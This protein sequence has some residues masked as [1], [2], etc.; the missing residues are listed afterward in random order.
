V[1]TGV[2]A[3]VVALPSIVSSI[4]YLNQSED[5]LL[6]PAQIGNLLGPV[7]WS[8]AF[9]IWFAFD[10]RL[11]EP[12]RETLTVIG[13]LLAALFTVFGVLDALARRRAALLLA[14]ITGLAG[15][16]VISSRY[17]I[18]F[19]AKSYMALAPALG[20]ATAAGVLWLW[21]RSTRERAGALVLGS[22]L[23]LGVLVS[24]GY[25][26]AGVWNTPKDRFQE[27]IDIG[28]RF[29]GKGP[30]LVNEREEYSK[31][32]LR[33]SLPWESWGSWQ[34]DRGLRF[35][36]VPAVPTTPDF[37]Y[38]TD[39][40]MARFKLLLE[41]KRPGGSRP[42]GNFEPVYE[43]AHYRVWRRVGDP[44]RVHLPLGLKGLSGSSHL[45]CGDPSAKRLLDRARRS[46]SRIRIAL[47]RSVPIVSEPKQWD[48]YATWGPTP[49]EGF[50]SWHSGFAV[51]TL[52]LAPGRYAVYIQGSFGPGVRVHAN[53]QPI[54]ET[55]GDLGI[56]DSW[57]PLG[58]MRTSRKET[59]IVLVGLEKSNLRPGS[60]R[61][62]ITGRLAFV[63]EPAEGTIKE[64]DG[65]RARS[66]CGKR[67]DWVELL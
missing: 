27:M 54:G 62:D 56:Q 14:L 29:R 44:P 22:L 39:A 58:T 63:R 23:A 9:N 13:I 55:F 30:L 8:E 60:R 17:A 49:T 47:P 18:Y 46:R 32:F 4:D 28:K 45:D 31:Y 12:D 65:R 20:L 3:L 42:P 36:T 24:D 16:I 10:Y 51:E 67:L 5:L 34:P 15:M 19:D 2:V 50:V 64:L 1:I 33:D 59:S 48:E 11:S 66:L 38:Y 26:Y 25:V 41:R 53:G 21:R 43:T 37:D 40:H 61:Y 35:P 7:P 57:Q 52:P 6:N